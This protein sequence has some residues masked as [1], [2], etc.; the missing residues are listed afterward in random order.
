MPDKNLKSILEEACN[1]I[2][3]DFNLLWSVLESMRHNEAIELLFNHSGSNKRDTEAKSTP[4]LYWAGHRQD[5]IKEF[6]QIM[7]SLG[8][9]RDG[10]KLMKLFKAPNR[11][12]H[13][14]LEKTHITVFLQLLAFIKDSGLVRAYNCKSIYM[15]FQ[16]HVLNFRCDY[17]KNQTGK[18][19]IDAVKKLKSWPAVYASFHEIFANLIR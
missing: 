19:R 12:L 17:M 4:G 16:Y 18:R 1:K 7:I 9:T 11:P 8:I 15:V 10:E 14:R 6:I 3:Y 2:G 5:D 13:I